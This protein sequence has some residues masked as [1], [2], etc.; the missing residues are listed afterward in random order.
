MNARQSIHSL[1]HGLYNGG[2]VVLCMCVSK[3]RHA[4]D[5][6]AAAWAVGWMGDAQ[7]V[8]DNNA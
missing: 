6:A 4:T 1:A 3:V 8:Y 2:Q 7:D 5:L